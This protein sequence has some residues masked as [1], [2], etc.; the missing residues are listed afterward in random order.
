MSDT[1]KKR[2]SVVQSGE[3]FLRIM[4]PLKNDLSPSPL[5]KNFD[6]GATVYLAFP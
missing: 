2:H 5:P 4:Y 3:N 6:A 1:K